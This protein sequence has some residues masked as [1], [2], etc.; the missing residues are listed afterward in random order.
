MKIT[1]FV[2]AER[3]GFEPPEPLSSSVFKT[4]AFDHSAIFPLQKYNLFS[5]LQNISLALT[6]KIAKRLDFGGLLARVL[7]FGR[8]SNEDACRVCSGVVL[9][10]YITL[11]FWQ[12]FEY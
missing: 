12:L 3:E 1:S 7:L 2:G 4:G 9:G 11:R 5:I 10:N 6:K 8:V